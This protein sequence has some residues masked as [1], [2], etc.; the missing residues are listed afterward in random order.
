MIS[1]LSSVDR[2]TY[3]ENVSII[4]AVPQESFN[5]GRS[6]IRSVSVRVW[7]VRDRHSIS[8]EQSDRRF[9]KTERHYRTP[10]HRFGLDTSS[11]TDRH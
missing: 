1:Q 11:S 8:D 2:G 6:G 5:G 10:G 9:N 3:H 7:V 4:H